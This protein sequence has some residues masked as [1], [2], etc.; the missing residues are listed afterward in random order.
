LIKSKQLTISELYDYSQ[1]VELLR[2]TFARQRLQ[3]LSETDQ[4]VDSYHSFARTNGRTNRAVFDG[5]VVASTLFLCDTDTAYYVMGANDPAYRNLGAN[6]ALI[7]D[8]VQHFS[9]RGISKIDLLS[10]NDFRR[11]SYK[12]SLAGKLEM[13][14]KVS[15]D[16]Q[17]HLSRSSNERF[18]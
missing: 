7:V 4:L 18:D 14:L 10:V 16:R 5:K 17:Q 3:L 12:T 6:T 9:C 11:G 8:Q 13:S 1:L 2:I 15:L